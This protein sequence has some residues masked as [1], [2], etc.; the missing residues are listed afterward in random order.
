M[1]VS[2]HQFKSLGLGGIGDDHPLGLAGPIPDLVNMD[3]RIQHG[4]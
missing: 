2:P 1:P 4:M 3:A